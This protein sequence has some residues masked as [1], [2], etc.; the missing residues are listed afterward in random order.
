MSFGI[1]L[2]IIVLAA[3]IAATLLAGRFCH[4]D[5]LESDPLDNSPD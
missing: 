2:T 1:A 5:D 4:M 3:V